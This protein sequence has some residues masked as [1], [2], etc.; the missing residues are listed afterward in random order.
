[1]RHGFADITKYWIKYEL[2]RKNIVDDGLLCLFY[3]VIFD[4]PGNIFYKRIII[5]LSCMT[6]QYPI[7][8]YY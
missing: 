6:I 2:M 7:Y 8:E 1:M 5:K 4:E 3:I